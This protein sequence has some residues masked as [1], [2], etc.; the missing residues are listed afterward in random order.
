MRY[1]TLLLGILSIAIV[2]LIH[3]YPEKVADFIDE[4]INNAKSYSW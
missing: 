2:S 4:K 1:I 3:F